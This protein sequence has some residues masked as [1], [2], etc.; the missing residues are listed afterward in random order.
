MDR[1]SLCQKIIWKIDTI[2]EHISQY[3]KKARTYGGDTPLYM[4]Q[5]HTLALIGRNPQINLNTLAELAEKSKVTMSQQVSRLDLLGLIRKTRNP[6]NQREI[7][8]DLTESGRQIFNYHEKD[9]TRFYKL[10]I[11]ELSIFT[12]QDLVTIEKFVMTLE[13]ALESDEMNGFS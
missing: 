1:Y 10:L 8:L 2:S 12:E 13:Q 5:V 7:L 6:Q 11:D 3:Q 9:D 4:Q